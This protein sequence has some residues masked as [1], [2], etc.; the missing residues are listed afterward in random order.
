[1]IASPG[2][3]IASDRSP[4]SAVTR[5]LKFVWAFPNTVIGLMLLPAALGSRSGMQTCDGVLEIHGPAIDWLLQHAVPIRGGAAAITFGHIVAGRDL[6][7]LE[8]TRAHERAHVRQCEVWGPAFIP[9]YLLASAWAW[10]QGYGAYE[11]NYFERQAR[12]VDAP[13]C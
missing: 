3:A 5:G 7:T 2:A 1:M 10:M 11:G 13:T 9:A 6:E 8:A 12:G 4:A